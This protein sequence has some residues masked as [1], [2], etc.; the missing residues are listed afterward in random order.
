[1]KS[2]IGLALVYSASQSSDATERNAGEL[3]D[4]TLRRSSV[5]PPAP[6]RADPKGCYGL[7]VTKAGNVTVTYL[8]RNQS[9]RVLVR[10]DTGARR[11]AYNGESRD[12]GST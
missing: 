10:E 6:P 1:M 2:R 9:A 12:L 11:G 4:Y 5:L 3:R 8:P 7:R